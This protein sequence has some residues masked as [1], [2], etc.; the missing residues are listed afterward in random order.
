MLAK[1]TG[2]EACDSALEGTRSSTCKRKLK[3]D[4]TPQG[5]AC[6]QDL[7]G[8][9]C[10]LNSSSGQTSR[11]SYCQLTPAH[12]SVSSS[13]GLSMTSGVGSDGA[14]DHG[15][16]STGGAASDAKSAAGSC[17]LRGVATYGR[18]RWKV[19]SV[20]E[21]KRNDSTWA[22]TMR[23]RRKRRNVAGTCDSEV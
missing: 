5:H 20:V 14:N 1:P 19:V 2:N 8:G 21:R 3:V 12:K 10:S 16:N 9:G 13:R 7:A 11:M 4:D 15:C 22:L 6:G 18:K 17:T 23:L